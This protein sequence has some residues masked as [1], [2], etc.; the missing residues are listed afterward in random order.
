MLGTKVSVEPLLARERRELD[1]E[2]AHQLVDAEARDL[3]PHRAGIEPRNVEQRAEDL[4]HGFERGI[5]VRDEPRVLAAALPLDQAGDVE[6]RRIERLQDV[7]ARG[8]EEARL[9]DVGLLGL[10][11]GARQRGVEAGQLLGALRTRRSRFSLARSSASAA[12]TLGVMSVA[13]VTRPPSGMWL[14]RIS[15]TR[16]RSAKRSRIG[17]PP[18]T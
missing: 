8:G 5:D 15:M 14:A 3:R 6:P 18:E 12:S 9:G 13:V 17:S 10:A 4:L 2:L 1:L 16:P 7:V 11:L